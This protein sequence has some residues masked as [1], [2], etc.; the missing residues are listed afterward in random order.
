MAA[1]L[2]QLT[3]HGIQCFV[4][5]PAY[6]AAD[7]E[8]LQGLGFTILSDPKGFLEIDENTLVFSI[9]PNVPI[10]QIVSD[11]QWPAMMIWNT[12]EPKEEE[13]IEWRTEE[14]EGENY[15]IS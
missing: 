10:K 4:Q 13:K 5:D 3:G 14:F 6:G 7:M 12:V 1:A 15:R 8:F 2:S 11:V 9:S